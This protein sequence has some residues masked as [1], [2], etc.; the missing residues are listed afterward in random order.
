MPHEHRAYAAI[1]AI[2]ILEIVALLRGVD[3]A[4]L[5]LVVASLAG[6]GGYVI[7]ARRARNGGQSS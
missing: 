2:T 3:G 5:S 7:G 4:V 6:L 1:A